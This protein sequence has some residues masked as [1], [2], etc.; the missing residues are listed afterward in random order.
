VIGCWLK[1]VNK[2]VCLRHNRMQDIKVIL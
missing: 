1:Y 2:I